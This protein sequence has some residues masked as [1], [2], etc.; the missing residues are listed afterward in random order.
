M[1]QLIHIEALEPLHRGKPY[2]FRAGVLHVVHEDGLLHKITLTSLRDETTAPQ[3]TELVMLVHGRWRSALASI[4]RSE[5]LHIE[6]AEI[7]PTVNNGFCPFHLELTDPTEPQSGNNFPAIYVLDANKCVTHGVTYETLSD[8]LVPSSLATK[9]RF[10]KM[11]ASWTTSTTEM[12]PTTQIGSPNTPRANRGMP[13]VTNSPRTANRTRYSNYEYMDLSTLCHNGCTLVKRKVNVFGVVIDGRAAM[14]TRGTDLRSEIQLIDESSVQPNG[15][16]AKLGVYIFGKHPSDSVPFRSFGDIVRIHRG[17]V[18][19]FDYGAGE[20]GVQLRVRDFSTM[21]MWRYDDDSFSPVAGRGPVRSRSCDPASSDRDDGRSMEVVHSVNEEDEIRIT[22]LRQWVA[23]YLH[24]QY[25]PKRKYLHTLASLHAPPKVHGDLVDMVCLIEHE[26]TCRVDGQRGGHLHL[27]VSD[28]SL[29]ELGKLD[30]KDIKS[31]SV[32]ENCVDRMGTYTFMDFLPCW[33]SKPTLP[34]WALVKDVVFRIVDGHERLNLAYGWKTSTILFQDERAP[35][36]RNVKAAVQEAT[37]SELARPSSALEWGY[38][39]TGIRHRRPGVPNMGSEPRNGVAGEPGVI[40]GVIPGVTP[41]VTPGVSDVRPG[42]PNTGLGVSAH[43]AAEVGAGPSTGPGDVAIRKQTTPAK[44][45]T[46]KRRA[47][48]EIDKDAEKSGRIEQE[49]RMRRLDPGSVGRRNRVIISRTTQNNMDTCTIA[50]MQHEVSTGKKSIYRLCVRAALWM[51]PELV[52]ETCRPVCK[53]CDNAY[54]RAVDDEAMHSTCEMMECVKC[55]TRFTEREDSRLGWVFVL[56]LW[57]EDDSKGSV[58]AWIEGD[59]GIAL[60]RGIVSP[61]CMRRNVKERELMH[62]CLLHM[63]T[64]RNWLDCSV[65]GYEYMD[66]ND[67]Y[68]VACKIVDTHLLA[69][70]FNDIAE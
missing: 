41:G 67:V 3:S 49:K 45:T 21:L 1:R 7:A 65:R 26:E 13:C 40:P 57:L 60:M 58:E 18:E 64:S 54:V 44:T 51:D 14:R 2:A 63:M 12:M 53:A 52:S 46:P 61:M 35:L 66:E 19:L 32:D 20:E 24:V 62:R 59:A 70:V 30:W 47:A 10:S 15:D 68:R 43:E 37:G 6:C 33:S 23:T 50:Q 11:K 69:D 9:H 42:L 34:A 38:S 39:L 27:R 31:E 36:V 55:G 48:S 5:I 22:E 8:G 4:S 17:H 16:L 56:L 29:D 28:G 25:Q